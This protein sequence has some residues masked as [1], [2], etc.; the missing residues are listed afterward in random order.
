ML[1]YGYHPPTIYFPL[2]VE[3]A[4]MI[5]PTE[6][7][8]K[9]T[10]DQFIET[11]HV[12]AKEAETDPEKLKHAPYTT[13]VRRLDE[14]KAAREP[15][16]TVETSGERRPKSR[17]PKSGVQMQADV[18]PRTSDLGR[19]FWRILSSP[20]DVRDR[21]HAPRR[22]NAPR[23]VERGDAVPTL[24]FFRFQEP[25]L[26]YGRL[27]KL[28]DVRPLLPDGWA[29]VQRPTGGGIV[30]HNGDLCFSLCWKDGQAPLPKKPQDQ[31]R[32]IHSV[33]LEALVAPI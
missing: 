5:E 12:I 33:V 25:T 28:D 23:N 1:D 10:L 2:I 9:Q 22:R 18:R 6:T 32:W 11:M 19:I 29:R 17:C 4:M 16:L 31:Y 3:E 20:P 13:P 7:E 8:S 30:L 14:V 26:S 27:Q 21:E 24:R 15:N